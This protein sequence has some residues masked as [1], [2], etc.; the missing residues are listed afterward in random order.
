[1]P[2]PKGVLNPKPGHMGLSAG[3]LNVAGPLGPLSLRSALPPSCFP[4][5]NELLLNRQSPTQV[6]PPPHSLL[7]SS[8]CPQHS[9][10]SPGDAVQS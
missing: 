4:P 7:Y 8:F 2:E 3:P 5:P 9:S 6:R 10:L 1:M